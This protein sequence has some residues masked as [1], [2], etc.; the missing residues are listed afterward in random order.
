MIRQVNQ[1]DP[2]TTC[3]VY[4]HCCSTSTH[5]VGCHP[6]SNAAEAA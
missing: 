1:R 6:L 2:I 4:P 5:T 3:N